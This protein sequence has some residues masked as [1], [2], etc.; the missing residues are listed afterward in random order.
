MLG[1]IAMIILQKSINA[2]LSDISRID[3][4]ISTIKSGMLSLRRDEKDF[5]MRLDVKYLQKFNDDF[6]PLIADVETLNTELNLQDVPATNAI[7]L[8]EVLVDYKSKFTALVSLQQSIGLDPTSGLYGELRDAVHQVESKINELS[9]FQLLANMLMLRRHEK[10]FMLRED[11]KYLDKFD[12]DFAVFITNLNKADIASDSKSSISLLM[13][14]Y[15]KSFKGFISGKQ[16][17]G[18]SSSEGAL[19]ELRKTIHQSETLLKTLAE[20]I[21]TA[22]VEHRAAANLVSIVIALLIT[23]VIVTIV[24]FLS[25]SISK[26]VRYLSEL[27]A[28]TSHNKD[29]TLRYDYAGPHEINEVGKSLN[30]MLDSFEKSMLEVFQSTLLL[31]S[32]S[33]ELNNITQNTSEGIRRQQL[34]TE[35]VATAMNEMTATVMEVSRAASDAATSSN[36]VDEESQNGAKLVRDTARLIGNLAK[37]VIDTAIEMDQLRVEAENINTVVQVIGSIAEQT[38]LLALN[39]AI[40]AARAGEQGRG[41]AV[42]ADEVRTLASRSQASTQEISQIIERLQAKTHSAV[43]VMKSGEELAQNCVKQAAIA[44]E[45]IEKITSAV[46]TI[47]N[48]NFQIASAAEQQNSVAEEINRNV[49]NINDIAQESTISAEETLQTSSAL[50]KLAADLQTIVSQFKLK[51]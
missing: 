17:L 39:A 42:V 10:D 12:K 1:M 43:T 18:L 46:S 25:I 31:S 6:K 35:S 34:E 13:Q 19:G 50:A 47:S 2:S 26:P 14:N 29:L 3:L 16:A 38:N 11:L 7:K 4:R 33:E 21:E 28:N 5:L 40:E 23:C 22:S 8:K 51:K 15:S 44:G 37:Q 48:Q 20:E 32:S 36:I 24:I 9:N 49:V 41:F 45:A 27:M 30:D